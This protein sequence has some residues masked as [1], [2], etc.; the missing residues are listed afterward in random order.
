MKKV[1][2]TIITLIIVSCTTCKSF[3][4]NKKLKIIALAPIITSDLILLGLEKN[5]TANTTYCINSASHTPEKIGNVSNFSTE[6]IISLSPDIVF[7]GELSNR[8]KVE[9]LKSMGLKIVFLPYPKTFAQMCDNLNKIAQATATTEKAK[10]LIADAKTK[11]EK[12]KIKQ[13]TNAPKVFVQIGADPLFTANKDSFINE[14]VNFAGGI[15]IAEKSTSGMYSKEAV[16]AANPDIILI[17]EMGINGIKEK[18]KWFLYTSLPA[19][20]NNNIYIIDEYMLCS[21]NIIKLPET[22]QEIKNIFNKSCK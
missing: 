19:V 10:E 8:A 11:I 2:I 16:I 20:K 15:N 12:L 7:C 9:K 13:L 22:L 18:E 17:S 1:F 6:K 4:A 14:L 21:P 3:A 5:I